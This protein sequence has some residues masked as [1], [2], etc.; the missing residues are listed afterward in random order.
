MRSNSDWSAVEQAVIAAAQVY[1]SAFS[2]HAVINVDVGL[3]E[4]NGSALNAGALGESESNGYLTSYATVQTALA[5]HDAALVQSGLMA[6]N[7]P[8]ALSG[9][10]GESF[11]VT[12]AEAKALNLTNAT[13]T[14]VDGFIGLTSSSALYFT[15]DGGAIAP[16]Q[17]D[18][19]GVAAHEL[20]E[21]LGR[22][23]MEGQSLGT[24]PNIYTPL[25]V[26]RYSAPNAPDIHPTA[27]YFSTN[28]G[29]INLGAYN[30]PANSGDAADWASSSAA[31]LNAFDAFATPGVAAQITAFLEVAAL[32]YQVNAGHTLTTTTI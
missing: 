28:N 20:S 6:A 1:T 23:G 22:I 19:V 5:S 32:G 17:Y 30:N 9:L 27:G 29:V 4:V 25:D 11:F 13:A 12:S 2:T 21:V 15:A 8:A 16:S 24:H 7:A 10:H 26:F 3:G 18:A 31:R 14:G